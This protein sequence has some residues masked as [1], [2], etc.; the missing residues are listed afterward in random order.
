MK[1]YI[2]LSYFLNSS[3]PLYGGKKGIEVNIDKSISKGDSANTKNIIFHNHSGTHIDFPNHFYEKGKTSSDYSANFWIF[4]C[5]F[6]YHIPKSQSE[7]IVP[8]DINLKDIP[9]N[10]DFLIFDTGFYKLRDDE[11]FWKFNPGVH[12]DVAKFLRINFPKLKVLGM[13]FISLTSYQHRVLGRKAHKSFLGKNNILLVEDINLNDINVQPKKIYCI[14]LLI[15]SID[16]SPVTLIA[17]I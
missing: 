11:S 6:I 5:P 12:P 15:E 9:S 2:Y 14:P 13:D 1:N 17:E 3:T 8:D 16:G 4:D 7:I 10:T